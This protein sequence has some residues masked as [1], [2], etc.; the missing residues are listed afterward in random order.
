MLLPPH[1]DTKEP[2][3][4]KIVVF[5]LLTWMGIFVQSKRRGRQLHTLQTHVA[6]KGLCHIAWKGTRHGYNRT[7][8]TTQTLHSQDGRKASKVILQS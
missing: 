5:S 1:K 8:K 6:H 4:S 2:G 3:L 7:S